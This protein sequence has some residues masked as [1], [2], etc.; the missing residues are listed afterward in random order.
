M[1]KEVNAQQEVLVISKCQDL[2]KGLMEEFRDSGKFRIRMVDSTDAADRFKDRRYDVIV[3]HGTDPISIEWVTT[4]A[5]EM[6]ARVILVTSTKKPKEVKIQ[7]NIIPGSDDPKKLVEVL[8]D[9]I[10]SHR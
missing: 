1:K 10:T 4:K 9:L 2:R 8:S 7:V 6:K 3:Y 5:K